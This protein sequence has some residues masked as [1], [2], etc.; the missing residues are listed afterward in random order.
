MDGV[1][2]IKE[3]QRK[4]IYNALNVYAAVLKQ[5]VQCAKNHGVA[6]LGTGACGTEIIEALIKMF[7]D[8]DID[9]SKTGHG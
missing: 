8:K 6:P 7:E 2:N 3:V 1:V 9:G 4:I 5:S